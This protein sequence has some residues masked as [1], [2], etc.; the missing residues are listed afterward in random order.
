MLEVH[1]LAIAKYVAGR[2]KDLEFLQHL[3]EYGLIQAKVVEER[4]GSRSTS[5][6]ETH[7]HRI[8]QQAKKHFSK[9]ERIRTLG[10]KVRGRLGRGGAIRGEP[11]K[12]PV[13]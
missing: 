8:R 6:P 10:E 3:A 13:R 1:D 7:R 9:S 4:L 11:C 5:I 12:R 2:K